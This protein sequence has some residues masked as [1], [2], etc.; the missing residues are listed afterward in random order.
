MDIFVG[1]KALSIVK[2]NIFFQHLIYRS[3]SRIAKKNLTVR[4][5]LMR[6][7]LRRGIRFAVYLQLNVSS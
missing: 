7:L 3:F 6:R 1:Q 2:K 5:L 4:I